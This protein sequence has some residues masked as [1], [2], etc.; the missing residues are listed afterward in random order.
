MKTPLRGHTVL[1]AC[2]ED[3]TSDLA[4]QL[5]A[6]GAEVWTVPTIR[7]VPPEDFGPLDA[8]LLEPVPFDWIIFTSSHGVTAFVDRARVLGLDPTG[9]GRRVATVGPATAATARRAGLHVDFTPARFVT[10]AISE[11]IGPLEGRRVLLPRA[12]IARPSL[13]IAL[14]GLGAIVR[15]VVAY[16]TVPA[17]RE[18]APRGPLKD[19]DTVVFTSASAVRGL[20]LALGPRS[21]TLKRH[22]QAACIGPVTAE[23]ARARGYG[24]RV[25]ATEHTVPGLIAALAA[26]VARYG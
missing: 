13:A 16:C 17:D 7:I 18:R 21:E 10:D 12:D 9:R 26:E 15:E 3:R 23:A 14:R 11:G 5:R 8:A 24:V 22:A 1:A 25:V 19:V 2:A 4:G 6:L 20:D